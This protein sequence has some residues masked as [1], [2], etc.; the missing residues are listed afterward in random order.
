MA[1]SVPYTFASA[2]GSL[3][4]SQLDANFAALLSTNSATYV[5]ATGALTYVSGTVFDIAGNQVVIFPVGTRVRA[6]VSAGVITGTVTAVSYAGSPIFQ[7][8][9][10][11][12]W[13]NGA[14]LDGG[15]SAV[16]YG[17]A[18]SSIAFA[19]PLA[20]ATPRTV[21]SKLTD[22]V[23][24]L[25]FGADNTGVTDCSTAI[26][27]AL[28]VAKSVY[29]PAGTYLVTSNITMPN[30]TAIM[31]AGKW[32]TIWKQSGTSVGELIL[33]NFCEVS[34][35]GMDGTLATGSSGFYMQTSTYSS[36]AHC[37]AS[38]ISFHGFAITNGY[39]N[40]IFDVES[41]N[42]GDRGVII[43]PN[44][45]YNTVVGVYAESCAKAAV[46][47]GHNSHHNTVTGVV[48]NNCGN[49]SV[50]IH[51][52]S[53]AN[54]VTNVICANPSDPTTGGVL[55]GYSAWDNVVSNVVSVGCAHTLL[56]RGAPPDSGYTARNTEYNTFQNISGYG[57]NTA[58]SSFILTDSADT[59]TTKAR[60]NTFVGGSCSNFAYA[61]NDDTPGGTGAGNLANRYMDINVNQIT[62]GSGT[63]TSQLTSPVIQNCSGIPLYRLIATLAGSPQTSGSVVKYNN[64]LQASPSGG[65]SL[66]TTTGV[67]TCPATGTY[68]FAAGVSVSNTSAAAVQF[69][70][71]FAISSLAV[72]PG[73]F[74]SPAVP[75]SGGNYQTQIQLPAIDLT[76]GDTV[77]VSCSTL[78]SS[79]S[80]NASNVTFF[81][82]TQLSA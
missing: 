45:Y 15:L 9:V 74:L 30:N 62:S 19:Q 23:S 33:S 26:N 14:S 76:V 42:C 18:A 63:P 13:D 49:Y 61:F 22:W 34:F 3:P 32:Q 27:N 24:V 4:L 79:L 31:G 57:T 20:N 58:S 80:V 29:F 66:N 16:A 36:I 43:D 70:L 25:D 69:G 28:A 21:Q 35:M 12:S 55:V 52:A 1:A 71:V 78:S 56:V 37:R 5:P 77:Q 44:C 60:Y 65:P 39:G 64:V 10:T 8:A 59:G 40:K 7:T 17:F 82:V 41:F 50:W 11:V 48:S 47:I 67:W 72:T 68:S 75:A 51:N 2:S 53:Y 73:V 81:C 6:T 46:L 54:A 38:N